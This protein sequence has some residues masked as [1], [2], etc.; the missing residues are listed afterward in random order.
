MFAKM[1]QARREAYWLTGSVQIWRQSRRICRANKA[2]LEAL[3][4]LER[5][6]DLVYSCALFAYRLQLDEKRHESQQRL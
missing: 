2:V 3:A 5:S 4:K 1:G 6:S